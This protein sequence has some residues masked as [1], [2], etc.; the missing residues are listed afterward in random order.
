MM[1]AKIPLKALLAASVVA[2]SSAPDAGAASVAHADSLTIIA[3]SDVHGNFFPYNFITSRPWAGSL[4]RVS[5]YV[6]AVRQQRGRE[7]VLLLDNGDF[8]QGQPTVYYYNYVDTAAPHIAALAY[9]ALGY[10]AATIGNHDIETGHDVYDR[11]VEECSPM[12]VLGAN[13]TDTST[14]RPYFRPYQIFERAGR[15]IA[16][17]GLTTPAVPAWLPPQLWSGMRFDDMEQSAREWVAHVREKERPDLIVGLFHSGADPSRDTAGFSENA[18]L[19]VARNVAG[20]DAVVFG[21]DHR[22]HEGV[23]E[24]CEGKQVVVLNPSC[25]ARAVARIDVTFPSGGDAPATVEGRIVDVDSM[26]SDRRFT[27]C[28][29]PQIERIKHYVGRTLGHATGA[30]TAAEALY[31]GS[32]FVDLLHRLQLEISGA[33]ISFAAPLAAD[34]EIAEGDVTVADMFTLYKFENMLCTMELTGREVLAYLE[35]SYGGWIRQ[36]KS[37]DEGMLQLTTDPVN[38]LATLTTP[39][40]NFDSAAGINYTVDLTRPEGSRVAISSMADGSEFSPGRVYRVAVNSYRANGGGDLMTLGAGISREELPRRIVASTDRD[41]RFYLIRQI[42]QA[43]SITPTVIGNWR[44]IPEDFLNSGREN[45][46]RQLA[47]GR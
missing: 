9:K 44:F 16:V 23:V 36:M 21:H 30:F 2:S 12:P 47:N 24:N 17:I 38:G 19:E 35:K 5:S 18:A 34:A 42:R 20:F 39:I 15:R 29:A 1:P 10:D 43:G 11:W 45:S 28:F 41:L 33:E 37:P 14:G 13:V 6:D 8:L 31:G 26:P 4:A 40:Y 27:Q 3:T 46:R 25:N 22:R 32:A 7:N